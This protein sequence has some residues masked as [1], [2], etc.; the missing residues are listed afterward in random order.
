MTAYSASKSI[1]TRNYKGPF[2]AS[3]QA[4]WACARALCC[5]MRTFTRPLFSAR[6]GRW[7]K[8]VVFASK[9]PGVGG[10]RGERRP[11][12]RDGERCRVEY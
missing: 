7:T 6:L 12:R 8:K 5:R 1:Y 3:G 9:G 2:R 4:I 10:P 11:T